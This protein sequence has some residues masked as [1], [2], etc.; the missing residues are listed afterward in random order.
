[1]SA[2]NHPFLI[3]MEAAFETSKYIVFVLEYCYGGEMFYLLR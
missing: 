2:L 1:M 3:K